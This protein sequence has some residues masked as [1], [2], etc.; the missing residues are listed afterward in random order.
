MCGRASAAD[1]RAVVLDRHGHLGALDRHGDRDLAARQG[2]LGGVADE[3]VEHLHQAQAISQHLDRRLG[4]RN[5]QAMPALLDGRGAGPHRHV[6]QAADVH[7]GALQ[8]ELAGADAR[9]VQQVVD[10]AAHVGDLAVDRGLQRVEGGLVGAGARQHLGSQPQRQ[11]RIAQFMGHGHQEG[12]LLACR[13]RSPWIRLRCD[14]STD[15]LQPLVGRA[16]QAHLVL[17]FARHGHDAARIPMAAC[18]P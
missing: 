11:Q 10:Q 18:G 3:V 5:A 17:A 2:V 9:A 6:D 15:K 8:P 13:R 12:G 7:H 16:Q 4:Q 14:S 1:P